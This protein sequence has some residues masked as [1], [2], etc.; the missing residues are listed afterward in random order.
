MKLF[1]K[2]V[3]VVAMAAVCLS[4]TAPVSAK[5]DGCTHTYVRK[6]Q[7]RAYA[8]AYEHTFEFE[9]DVNGDGDMEIVTEDCAYTAYDVYDIYLC[10]D[11]KCNFEIARLYYYEELHRSDLCDMYRNGGYYRYE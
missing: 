11:S 8:G 2:L 9:M 3:A 1:K 7:R 5:A 6:T 4:M 10:A